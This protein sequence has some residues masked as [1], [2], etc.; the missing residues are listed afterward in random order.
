MVV[1]HIGGALAQ[2][3]RMGIHCLHNAGQ[4]KQELDILIRCVARIQQIYTVIRSQRT[5]GSPAYEWHNPNGMAN[6]YKDN[7][8]KLTKNA[9]NH[10][11]Q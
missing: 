3:I 1:T 5:I 10:L 6:P 8:E 9:I 11:C 2:Q 7:M 4:Y